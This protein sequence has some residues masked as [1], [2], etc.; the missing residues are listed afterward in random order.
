MLKFRKFFSLE[1]LF[2][3]LGDT[4]LVWGQLGWERY[5]KTRFKDF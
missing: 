3:L 5:K 4:G 1:S 2:F